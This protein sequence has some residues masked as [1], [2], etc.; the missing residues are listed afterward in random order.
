MNWKEYELC[1]FWSN[2]QDMLTA[3]TVI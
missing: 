1:D 3:V 2:G